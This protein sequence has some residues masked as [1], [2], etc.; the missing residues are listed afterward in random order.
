MRPF[1]VQYLAV[2]LRAGVKAACWLSWG[3]QGVWVIHC[4]KLKQ[5]N[6]DGIAATLTNGFFAV[7]AK[8]GMAEGRKIVSVSARAARYGI[9]GLPGYVEVVRPEMFV[10][11]QVERTRFR[12]RMT[13]PLVLVLSGFGQS[14]HRIPQP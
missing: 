11:Y 5:P 3:M 13:S 10:T 9:S 1:H 4:S 7:K 6:E 12:S 14:R 2:S 8:F